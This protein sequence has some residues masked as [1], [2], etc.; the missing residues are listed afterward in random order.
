MVETINKKIIPYQNGRR[1][2]NF[3]VME[4]ILNKMSFWKASVK[5][6]RRAGWLR[7]SNLFLF[8]TLAK[9]LGC[10]IVFCK[11]T[12]HAPNVGAA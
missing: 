3:I 1:A 12:Q 7:K 9:Q 4:E 5:F 11:T 6:E 8:L 2:L 10:C